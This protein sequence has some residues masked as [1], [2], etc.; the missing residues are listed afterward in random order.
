[1]EKGTREPHST[2]RHA[3]SMAESF[4]RRASAGF[5]FG[6]YLHLPGDLDSNKI[7]FIME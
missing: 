3:G 7:P 1:M 2:L 6:Y 5:A 4:V